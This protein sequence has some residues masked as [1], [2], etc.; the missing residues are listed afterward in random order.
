MNFD[1]NPFQQLEN[2]LKY[3]KLRKPNKV[4]IFKERNIEKGQIWPYLAT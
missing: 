4:I 3:I 2:K 1:S